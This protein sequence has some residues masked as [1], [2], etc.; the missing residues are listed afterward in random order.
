MQLFQPDP[1]LYNAEERSFS[2]RNFIDF[3]ASGDSQTTPN[4]SGKFEN[5]DNKENDSD[6]THSE[7]FFDKAFHLPIITQRKPLINRKQRPRPPA[8]ATS[9]E[10]KEFFEKQERQK[11]QEEKCRDEK[12]AA[13]EAK[14]QKIAGEKKAQLGRTARK[15]FTRKLKI[16][17][18]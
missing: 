18:R 14:K 16:A 4:F 9:D 15:N 3:V 8:V 2:G 17:M 13:R 12:R 1:F 11:L 5:V 10:F 7:D 6:K